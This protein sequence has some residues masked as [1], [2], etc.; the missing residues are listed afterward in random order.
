MD[1]YIINF[2][3]NSGII[4][5]SYIVFCYTPTEVATIIVRAENV[6]YTF[7]SVAKLSNVYD[8]REFLKLIEP[9][10]NGTDLL[11]GNKE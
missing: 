9:K 1:R 5:K 3:S 8:F 7:L 2:T 10:D 4:Q 6:G 11:F